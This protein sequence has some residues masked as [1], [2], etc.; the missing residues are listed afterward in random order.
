M[1]LIDRYP[2][3]TNKH[4]ASYG[5]DVSQQRKGSEVFDISYHYK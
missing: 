4:Q 1:F 5:E 3:L 2:L